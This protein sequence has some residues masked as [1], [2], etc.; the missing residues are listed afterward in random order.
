MNGWPRKLRAGAVVA[1][2]FGIAWGTIVWLSFLGVILV[3]SG[4]DGVQFFG[5][6]VLLM[7]GIWIAIGVVHGAVVAAAM[8]LTGGKWTVDTFPRWLGALIGGGIGATGWMFVLLTRGPGALAAPTMMTAIVG[9]FG[10]VSTTTL[11]TIAR[12][13][14]LPP[15]SIEPDQLK[16]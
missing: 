11:L 1:L 16:S 9:L 3:T 14:A 7:F 10:V 12:R 15:A 13:G 4:F 8:S 6:A 5:S 2:A